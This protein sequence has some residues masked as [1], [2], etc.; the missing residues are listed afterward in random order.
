MIQKSI[1]LN[2]LWKEKEPFNDFSDSN[3]IRKKYI[4]KCIKIF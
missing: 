1:Y 3:S 2:N 4:N